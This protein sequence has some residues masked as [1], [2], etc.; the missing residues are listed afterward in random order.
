MIIYG[1]SSQP[2]E[3]TEDLVYYLY[4]LL[5]SPKTRQLSEESALHNLVLT[6]FI[7]TRPG[8]VYGLN[9][10]TMHRYIELDFGVINLTWKLFFELFV[11]KNQTQ[12]NL[13]KKQ[14]TL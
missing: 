8:I 4:L 6:I 10:I 7:S 5:K 14:N 2:R 1:S 13:E 9:M 3:K 12:V 11:H